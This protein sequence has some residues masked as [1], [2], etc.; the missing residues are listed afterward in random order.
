MLQGPHSGPVF[1]A[2]S[3]NDVTDSFKVLNIIFLY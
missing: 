2:L 3:L 1:H